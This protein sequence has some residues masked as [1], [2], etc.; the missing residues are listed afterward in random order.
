MGMFE[1]SREK[2]IETLANIPSA[3]SVE[4]V[5]DFCSLARYYAMKTPVTFRKVSV[6]IHTAK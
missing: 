6:Y 1:E 5:S 4:D 3:L 2:I